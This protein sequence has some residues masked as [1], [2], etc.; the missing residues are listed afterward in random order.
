MS[1]KRNLLEKWYQA[2][3]V[4]GDL[5]AIEDY[6]SPDGE[7]E[8]IVPGLSVDKEEF[9]E[10][11]STVRP[12]MNDIEVS[13]LH[14]IEQDDWLSA[15]V[16]V[17]GVSARNSDPV[18]AFSHVMIR[19]QNTCIVEAYYG[20]DTLTFFEQLGQLPPDTMPQLLSGTFLS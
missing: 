9:K 12:M 1:A 4:E 13:V 10:L 19:V 3:W 8:G 20:F 15:L 17:R 2:V 14:S 16:E 6:F 5:H 7:A 18:H 11:V